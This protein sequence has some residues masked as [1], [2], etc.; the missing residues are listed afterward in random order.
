M[1]EYHFKDMAVGTKEEFEVT[2]TEEKMQQFR[3]MSGDVNPL[4][5]EDEYGRQ[6]GFREKV[7]YGMLSASFY[8]T[9]AGVYLPGKYCLLHSVETLFKKPVYVGDTLK[10]C[11]EI[12]E[13]YDTFKQIKIK[14]KITNQYG[15]VV[16]RGIIKAGV[17]ND[18]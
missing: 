12:A 14:A 9:L 11:G 2:I 5:C 3:A 7:V 15:E 10:I 18:E 16:N 4:H 1:K 8:S 6:Q 17:I 13:L